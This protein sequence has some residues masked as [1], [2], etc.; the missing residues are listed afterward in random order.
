MMIFRYVYGFLLQILPCAFFCC[1]PFADRFK[2]SARRLAVMIL[3]VTFGMCMIFTILGLLID[4]EI[5]RNLN[6]LVLNLVFFITLL[7]LL[8]IYCFFIQAYLFEKL[9]VFFIIM[10]YGFMT[11]EFLTAITNFFHLTGING[12]YMY[13]I[14]WLELYSVISLLLF[15]PMKF[16]LRRVRRAFETLS[17]EKI[18]QPFSLIPAT[19][20]LLVFFCVHLPQEAGVEAIFILQFFLLSCFVF[21]FFL[22]NWMFIILEKVKK[23]AEETMTLQMVL[24]NYQNSMKNAQTIRE[25]HHEIKHHMNAISIYLNHKDYSGAETYL[26]KWSDSITSLPTTEYTPHPLIN[27]IL[28]EYQDK[29]QRL[30]IRTNYQIAVPSR[31]HIDD[32]DLCRFLTNLLDNALEGCSHV[33]SPERYITLQIKK[34]GQF[35]FFSCENSCQEKDLKL[36]GGQFQSTKPNPGSHGLG[37]PCMHAIAEHYNGVFRAKA[38]GNVFTAHANLCMQ[39]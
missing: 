8:L 32:M 27:S 39:E 36:V 23:Q 29:A 2:I 21:L 7:L 16:L 24:N 20:I 25:M 33:E 35:L 12:I 10:N 1:Y 14:Q 26:Q 28:T 37:I 11:T 19:F 34:D 3:S 4:P 31:L 38:D 9:F 30:D 18:W 15:F 22:Y 5:S 6:H 17:G 13:D